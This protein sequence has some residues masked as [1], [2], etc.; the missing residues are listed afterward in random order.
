[1]SKVKYIPAQEAREESPARWE[2][3]GYAIERDG[4]EVCSIGKKTGRGDW[5]SMD[6]ARAYHAILGA[7]LGDQPA[8]S[9]D[10]GCEV[11]AC[12][13]EDCANPKHAHHPTHQPAASETH[14]DPRRTVG[15]VVK[16]GA[17]FIVTR[18][19]VGEFK[20]ASL[21]YPAGGTYAYTSDKDEFLRWATRAECERHGIPYVERD[22]KPASPAASETPAVKFKVGD[23]VRVREFHDRTGEVVGD[24]RDRYY[25]VRWDA[26][27]DIG[28]A[29]PGYIEAAPPA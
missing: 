17:T 10:K 13:D 23:K 4:D 26:T 8:A 20:Q 11:C 21:D 19:G 9:D 16:G 22:A 2:L 1:M 12:R 18:E 3:D 29:S 7:I 25:R 5:I 6:A 27:N 24:L 28:L 14:A 15:A